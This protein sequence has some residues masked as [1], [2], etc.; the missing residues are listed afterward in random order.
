MSQ[1]G[2]GSGPIAGDWTQPY[3][4]P[5]ETVVNGETWLVRQRTTEPGTY[6]FDWV[7]GPNENYGFT[8][9]SSDG[10]ASTATEID[11]AIRQFLTDVDPET[12]YISED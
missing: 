3:D 4:P 10:S 2:G 9:A 8:L 7:S 1:S 12:G 6:D 11:D 5:Y